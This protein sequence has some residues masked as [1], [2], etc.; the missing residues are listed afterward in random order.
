MS[1]VAALTPSSHLLI[2]DSNNAQAIYAD[3][4]ITGLATG[5]TLV[6]IDVRPATGELYGLGS[7]GMLY[8]IDA[9]TGVASLVAALAADPLDVDAPFT[10]LSGTDFGVDFNPVADRLR[11]VSDT[12]ASIRINPDTALVTTDTNLTYDPADPIGGGKVPAAA[13]AAYTNDVAGATTT[14]L[15]VIDKSF[16]NTKTLVDNST[17]TAMSFTRQGGVDGAPSPNTGILTTTAAFGRDGVTPLGFDIAPSGTAFTGLKADFSGG[18]RYLLVE[19]DPNSPVDSSHGN[20]GDG[21]L[22]ISDIA[23]LPTVQLS[24]TGYVGP[25]GGMATVTVTR[26]EG[27]VG[28]VTV[29]VSS[30]GGTA[31]PGLDFTPVDEHAHL[32][33][34]ARRARP[35]TSPS[36]MTR[37]PRMMS[38]SSST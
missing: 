27:S 35:S 17:V 24:A 23:I 7:A 33:P 10:A 19:V 16:Y 34:P 20:I 4:T 14:T 1:T 36:P 18:S 2:F 12:G 25:E 38:S 31:I 5:D 6:G 15:F 13:D 29:D 32:S 3:R 28:T 9:S 26:T 8:T 37:S 30:L 21:S 11:V 22:E